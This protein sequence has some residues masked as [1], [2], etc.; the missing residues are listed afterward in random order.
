MDKKKKKKFE[1]KIRKVGLLP[2]RD[3]E[4]GYAPAQRYSVS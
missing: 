4:A 1:E 3:C 2:N